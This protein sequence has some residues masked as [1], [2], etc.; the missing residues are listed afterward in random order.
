MRAVDE[1]RVVAGEKECRLGDLLGRTKTA[2][3]KR[4]CRFACIETVLRERGDF[5][6]PVRGI[7]ETRTHR[8]AANT[9]VA[10]LHGDRPC[11]HRARSLGRAIK[12][13]ERGGGR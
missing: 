12:H 7:D 5:T 9:T 8:V 3:L 11:E 2:L 1:T 6:L 4:E 13:F 10:I